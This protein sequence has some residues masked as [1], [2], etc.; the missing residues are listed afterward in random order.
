MNTPVKLGLFTAGLAT[1]F[2]AAA[3]VG[4]VVDPVAAESSGPASDH[5]AMDPDAGA[6]PSHGGG[7]ESHGGDG[8]DGAADAT[9]LPGGLMVSQRGYTL[10][11]AHDTAPAGS[12]VPLAFA[13]L[14][15]DGEPVTAYQ[16][17]HDKDLHLIVARRDLTGFQ[18]VHPRLGPDGTWAT[19]LALSPGD[20]RVFADFTPR[21]QDRPVTLGADL[22]VAGDYRPQPL[23]APAAT[24][25]VGDYEVTLA[26]RLVPGEETKLDLSVSRNGR[27]VTDLQPY[28]AAYGHLVALRDGDLAYVHVHPQGSPGDGTTRPG[29][30]IT[31]HTTA[32]SAG[33][34]R[35]FLD[36]RHAGVVR[37]AQ[38]TVTAGS[39]GDGHDTRPH[40]TR[41]HTTEE[42][43]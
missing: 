38:F 34:Y 43:P 32:P 13:V 20:W 12:A 30:T 35:L 18:H 3:G 11:L 16:R 41:P 26:G 31:F 37:T 27:P 33:S 5:A 23:P 28:L 29:P 8:A 40:T 21:G 17:S 14:G 24:A 1:A 39:A 9:D 25:R 4:G 19:S 10:A 2:A 22:A 7:E 15:P 42:T 36:F 6:A